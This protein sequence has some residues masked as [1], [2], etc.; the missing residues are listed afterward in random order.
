MNFPRS[1]SLILLSSGAL[2]IAAA[3]AA[4]DVQP[5][6]TGPTFSIQSPVRASRAVWLLDFTYNTAA[7]LGASNDCDELQAQARS[8]GGTV[9]C[10]ADSHVPAW[11]ASGGLMFVDRIGFKAGYLDYGN[12][13]LHAAGDNTTTAGLP[14]GRATIINTTFSYDA[15]LGR[16]RGVTFV[17]IARAPIGRVVPFV[18]A[19]LWRWW[20]RDVERSQFALTING[21]PLDTAAVSDDRT[22]ASWDPVL[23]GGAEVWL[24]RMIAVNGGVRFVRLR[25]GNEDVDERFAG[26]FF[27]VR[28][29]PRQ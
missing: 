26:I 21:R 18:E 13:A 1:L 22:K 16:A 2:T 3:A 15:E 7:R 24:T 12:I 27:G 17:G 20:V 4:Q 6:T 9:S 23:S 19:G 8:T 5:Q 11:S 28:V 14:D 25:T 10:T 29:S